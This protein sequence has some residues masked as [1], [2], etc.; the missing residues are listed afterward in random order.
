[1]RKN[2]QHPIFI[3]TAFIRV[4][5][6]IPGLLL[7][8]WLSS[9]A[10]S[11]PVVEIGKTK[12]TY[13]DIE[14]RMAIAQIRGNEGIT[15]VSALTQL[16]NKTMEYEVAGMHGIKASPEEIQDFSNYIDTTTRAPKLL[17]KIKEAFKGDQTAYGRLYL[18]PIIINRKL[19][20]WYI[21]NEEIHKKERALMEKAFHL[22]RS[23]TTFERAAQICSLKYASFSDDFGSDMAMIPDADQPVP[24]RP[25]TPMLIVVESL[26]PGDIFENIVDDVT[27]YKI[28]K[29][30]KKDAKAYT[31]EMI[32][33]SKRPFPEWYQEQA[34]QLPLVFH[35]Q[36]LKNNIIEQYQKVWWV[37]KLAE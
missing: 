13:S 8:N 16:I 7:I 28:V 5:I 30:L 37:K 35:D 32:Y 11:K 3:S 17:A 36:K 19:H 1:M 21:Q 22:V 12:I 27:N 33:T 2:N 9:C 26:K 25:K 14:Y 24:D 20:S 31:I 23:D 4:I 18:M 29:L 10:A 34:D 15:E 6:L